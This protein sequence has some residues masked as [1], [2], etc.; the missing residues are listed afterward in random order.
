MPTAPR[1]VPVPD[2]LPGHY[3][4][5]AVE[6]VGP[7]MPGAFITYWKIVDEDGIPYFP[8]Y[9]L[10]ANCLFRTVEDIPMPDIW[11]PHVPRKAPS[12]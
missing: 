1:A 11:I 7:P 3:V 5:V 10:G 9:P 4:D 8:Q 6:L 2:T 12:P